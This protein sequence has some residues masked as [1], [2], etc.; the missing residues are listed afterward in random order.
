MN[1]RSNRGFVV[2]AWMIWTA[3]VAIVGAW[4]YH[5]IKKGTAANTPAPIVNT[6]AAVN[7]EADKV[8][9]LTKKTAE[10]ESK[11][12]NQGQAQAKQDDTVAG[13]LTAANDSL[14]T[15]PNPNV[16]N[17]VANQFVSD[18][19]NQLPA[20]KTETERLYK[21]IAQN[22]LRENATLQGKVLKLT[23]D[24]KAVQD[25]NA[26][27]KQTLTQTKAEVVQVRAENKQAVADV[28]VAQKQASDNAAEVVIVKQ[29]FM[30]RISKISWGVGLWG[31]G[32][33]IVLLVLFPLLS[34]AFP[35][36]APVI[37]I[38]SGAFL[39]LWHKIA[40][41]AVKVEADAHAETK[42]VLAE[43]QAKHEA[44]QAALVQAHAT[45]ATIS[46]KA[47]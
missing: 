6:V 13:I 37:K 25:D 12:T 38:I 22:L 47:Q 11:L 9:E 1:I 7:T 23:D 28:Q 2:E 30:E 42:R 32:G 18:A 14:S 15:D 16:F 17:K 40:S 21:S 3:V 31:G 34:M 20:P 41:T 45:I 35:A 26:Q 27:T 46:G 39:G 29:T 36:L 5:E 4:G 10:L 43:I 19:M 8:A 44:T 24:Y 33:L